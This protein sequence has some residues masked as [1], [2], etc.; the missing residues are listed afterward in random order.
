MI[1]EVGEHIGAPYMVLEFLN[2][3]PLTHYIK[4]G[5]KLP[6]TRTVEIMNRFMTLAE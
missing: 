2:G 1:Y 5:Q 6:Y 3:Q 4:G